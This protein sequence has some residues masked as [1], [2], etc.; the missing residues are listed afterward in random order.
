MDAY[1]LISVHI[2]GHPVLELGIAHLV[3]PG[4]DARLHDKVPLVVPGRV[5]NLLPE[6]GVFN[7]VGGERV[8]LGQVVAN[9]GTHHVGERGPVLVAVVVL[10]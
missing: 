8:A 3:L 10:K 9:Q 4:W 5:E 2:S 6:P 1:L 7:G